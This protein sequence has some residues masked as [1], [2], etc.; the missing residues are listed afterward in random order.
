MYCCQSEIINYLVRST[1]LASVITSSSAR[2]FV[3]YLRSQSRTRLTLIWHGLTVR[4]HHHSPYSV[5]LES[6]SACFPA[7]VIEMTLRRKRDLEIK[8]VQLVIVTKAWDGIWRLISFHDACDV[9]SF[10]I[11]GR[12]A[13]ALVV[14][15]Q[16]RRSLTLDHSE[17]QLATPFYS[18]AQVQ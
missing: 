14:L 17:C 16:F 12:T 15:K 7:F 8:E 5:Q 9:S 18:S 1:Q 4:N 11:R 13:L 6:C 10:G 3:S 2:P